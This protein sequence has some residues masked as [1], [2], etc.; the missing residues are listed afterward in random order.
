[1]DS[2]EHSGTPTR[3]PASAFLMIDS[4]DRYANGEQN[5]TTYYF[6]RLNNAADKPGNDFSI[7]KR[8]PLLYGIF[9]RVGM[10]QLQLQYRVPTIVAGKNDTFILDI[11]G[12][13][14]V[15]VVLTQGY[16]TATAL[17]AEI[18]SSVLALPGTPIPGFT[19]VYDAQ[20]GGFTCAQGAGTIQFRFGD[21]LS[22]DP[23][24]Y[25]INRTLIT[26]G[27]QQSNINTY[28]TTQF[29]GTPSLLYTRF[30]DIVSQRLAKFQRVKDA[31]TLNTN[32]SNI[33]TRIYMTAPN[34]R[35]DPATA[36]GPIDICV[37]PNTPKH[38]MWSIDEA[39]YELDFQLYDEYGELLYW[40][41]EYNTEFQ[42]SL[43]A[44]ET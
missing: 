18:Q 10:V 2:S 34:T 27:A 30:I 31:D 28:A 44:S 4:E 32:K 38:S 5:V 1:M 29:L 36:C 39:I 35:S 19:C 3:P 9:K 13:G 23:D 43:L 7:Q 41:P 25:L 8:Q 6:N 11:S 24:V 26:I 21:V 42:V 14:D 40:S 12:V 22:T 15:P 16:Y 17:A 20:Y 37:D 33:L